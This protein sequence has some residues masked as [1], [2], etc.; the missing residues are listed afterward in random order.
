MRPRNTGGEGPL[1]QN[2]QS[3]QA[4][5]AFQTSARIAGAGLPSQDSDTSVFDKIFATGRQ[6]IG[7]PQ[8]RLYDDTILEVAG[9][10]GPVEDSQNLIS[11]RLAEGSTPAEQGD[12]QLEPAYFQDELV[13][14]GVHIIPGNVRSPLV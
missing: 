14:R 10:S 9:S 11:E 5:K 13:E 4:P 6:P 12:A 7:A 3:L 1:E 2:G 8:P